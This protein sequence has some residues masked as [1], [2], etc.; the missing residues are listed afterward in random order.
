MG[1]YYTGDIEG[2]FWFGVQD[3][4][5][6]NHF[7]GEEIETPEDVYA[8]SYSFTKEDL[9]DI[10]KG[11]QECIDSL[12]DK[13]P[14]LEEYFGEGGKGHYGYN[15]EE[16]CKDFELPSDNMHSGG[17]EYREMMEQYARL[18]LGQKIKDCVERTGKCDFG[19]EL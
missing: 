5:D 12:G 17:M 15:P 16:M 6:A 10:N 18:I 1:R 3:S 2:K 19:C 4:D 9:P 11:I 8:L 7:G 13:L 14:K